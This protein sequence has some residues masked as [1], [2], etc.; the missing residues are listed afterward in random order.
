M[1]QHPIFLSFHVH[2]ITNG[3]SGACF[4]T[5]VTTLSEFHTVEWWD[6]CE[7]VRLWKWLWPTSRHFPTIRQDRLRKA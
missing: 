4:L 6:G 1:T 2:V 5:Y 7:M 3:N